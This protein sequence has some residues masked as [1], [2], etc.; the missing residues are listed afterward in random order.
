MRK[1]DQRLIEQR[2]FS[3]WMSRPEGMRRENDTE[4]FTREVWDEGLRLSRSENN[5]YQLVMELIR[6]HTK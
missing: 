5:H 3:M 2:I 4:R 6:S 1:M